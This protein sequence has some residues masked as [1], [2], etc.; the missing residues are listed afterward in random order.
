[1]TDSVD[2][3]NLRSMTDGDKELEEALFSEFCS[4]TEAS[5]NAMAAYC[6]DGAS[7]PWRAAAHALKGTAYN[8]GATPL[9]ELCK[10]AQEGYMA[11][12]S[13]KSALLDAMRSEYA[14]VKAYLES[15]SS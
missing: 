8:L 1:M 10:K 4:S 3:T 13:E 2:L 14:K 6:V 12:G 11:S 5:L 15:I 7:E 9:G